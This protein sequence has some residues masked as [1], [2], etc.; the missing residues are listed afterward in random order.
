[1]KGVDYMGK[2]C[3]NTVYFR[4]GSVLKLHY[5]HLFTLLEKINLY[6]GQ[7]HLL[8]IL[9]K[10]DGLRQKDISKRL[11]VA[12]ATLT[13]M[14]K[15]LEKEGLVYRE[16]D[17]LDGRVYRVYISDKGRKVSEEAKNIFKII[18]EDCFG[19]FSKE[20]RESLD[21]ILSKVQENLKNAIKND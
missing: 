12:P 10:K 5:Q 1:M 3:G 17:P 14:I 18:E 7:P 21:K 13:M 11:N 19:N 4:F 15:R 9:D 16:K 6:P 8:F 20:E 2:E